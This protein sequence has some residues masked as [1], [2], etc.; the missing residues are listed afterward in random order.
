MKRKGQTP[1]TVV[2]WV[3]TF[4]VVWF[5]FLGGF[6]NSQIKYAIDANALT[7]AEAFILANFNLII[8]VVMLI[9]I[10]VALYIT[11]GT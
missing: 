2:F 5:L 3:V 6:L 7:G 1:I 11:G 9:F 10:A 8:Y 4:T